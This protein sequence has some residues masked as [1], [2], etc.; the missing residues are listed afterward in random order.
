M[1]SNYR[2]QQLSITS[3]GSSPLKEKAGPEQT[4]FVEFLRDSSRYRGLSSTGFAIKP[5]NAFAGMVS[6]LVSNLLKQVGASVWQTSWEFSLYR[7]VVRGIISYIEL[8]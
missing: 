6:G 4:V 7:G 3:I 2:K 5:E 1:P 8:T